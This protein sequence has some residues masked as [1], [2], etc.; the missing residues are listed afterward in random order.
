MLRLL[1][2]RPGDAASPGRTPS[3]RGGRA[4]GG[5]RR[6]GRRRPPRAVRTAR[7]RAAR[8][9]SSTPPRAAAPDRRCARGRTSASIRPRRTGSPTRRRPPS[10]PA[11]PGRASATRSPARS[12]PPTPPPALRRG[13]AAAGRRP[14]DAESPSRCARRS[15]GVP[16]PPPDLGVESVEAVDPEDAIA[17]EPVVQL[18]ERGGV[19]RV[20]AALPLLARQHEPALAQHAQVPRHARAARLELRGDLAGR[21]LTLGQ[22]LHDPPP[23]RF[24]QHLERLHA[25]YVTRSLRNRQVTYGRASRKRPPARGRPPGGSVPPPRA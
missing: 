21:L 22:Q 15:L 16:S 12:A 1:R 9:G 8:P 3:W 19:E 6:D 2:G 11:A 24:R 13:G 18:G 25:R 7:G 17:R 23:R 10:P 14:G 5:R 20:D 4:R